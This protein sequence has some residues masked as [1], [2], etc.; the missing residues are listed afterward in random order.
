MNLSEC[1]SLHQE[2]NLWL[3]NVKRLNGSRKLY[4][5]CR[6]YPVKIYSDSSSIACAA[7]IENKHQMVC[8]QMLSVTERLQSSTYKELLGIKV[9][10][11]SFVPVLKHQEVQF[12][13]RFAKCFENLRKR[14]QEGIF[15]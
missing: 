9:A 15:A 3:S 8:H 4:Q 2:L 5:L 13:F 12:L 7:F 10:V 6:V 1:T 11:E 14:Q